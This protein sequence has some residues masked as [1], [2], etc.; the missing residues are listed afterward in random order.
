MA[1]A[2]SSFDKVLDLLRTS[3]VAQALAMCIALGVSGAMLL[4]GREVPDWW[5]GVTMLIL[6]F[7]FGGKV[8][9]WQLNASQVTA[10]QQKGIQ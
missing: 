5:Q 6:G 8:A 3:V 1:S 7:Y 10:N 9:Q 2:Q 4:M